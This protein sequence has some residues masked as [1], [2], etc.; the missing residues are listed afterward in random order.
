MNEWVLKIC[1]LRRALPFA[2][3]ELLGQHPALSTLT[4]PCGHSVA[5]RHGDCVWSQR[6][7]DLLSLQWALMTQLKNSESSGTLLSSKMLPRPL[8][9]DFKSKLRDKRRSWPANTMTIVS[10]G[11]SPCITLNSEK[12]LNSTLLKPSTLPRLNRMPIPAGKFLV[13]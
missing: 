11:K 10:S 2:S 1:W 5:H 3:V 9:N 8:P 7:P 4:E 6:D 13:S 12:S